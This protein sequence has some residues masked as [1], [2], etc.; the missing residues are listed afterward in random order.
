MDACSKQLRKE[1]LA[2]DLTIEQ[3]DALMNKF[4]EDVDDGTWSKAG[5]ARNTYGT[6]KIGVSMLTR[7]QGR[8]SND[9]LHLAICPGWVRTDMGGAHASK[10][11]SEGADTPAW[12][13]VTNALNAKEHN[14]TFWAERQQIKWCSSF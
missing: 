10:S 1:F 11:G 6:S 3:L 2:D 5:W 9:I 8:D 13:A 12:A 14:G 7:I 4:I